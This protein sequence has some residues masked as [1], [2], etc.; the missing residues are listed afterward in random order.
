LTVRAENVSRIAAFIYEPIQGEAGIYPVPAETLRRAFDLCREHNVPLIADEVQTFAR[1]GELLASHALGIEPDYILLA[2]GLGGGIC[3][4]GMVLIRR[5]RY[6]VPFS[7]LHSSTFAGDELSSRVALKTLEMLTRENGALLGN[8]KQRGKRLLERLRALQARY[9]DAI[10]D[11]RGRGLMIGVEFRSL[12]ELPSW[13]F[14][15]V[16]RASGCPALDLCAYLVHETGVRTLPT[17]GQVN[18]IRIEPPLGINDDT[19]DRIVAAIGQL[20][21]VLSSGDSAAFLRHK[22]RATS[23]M[24][25]ASLAFHTP[26]P[27]IAIAADPDCAGRRAAFIC[28]PV[29]ATEL[30]TIDP[31][32][33]RLEKTE[34]ERL[35]RRYEGSIAPHILG[36]TVVRSITGARVELVFIGV[37]YTSARLAEMLV[38]RDVR[39]ARVKIQQA[40]DVA[41]RLGCTVCGLGQYSSIVTHNGLAVTH[42][43][44]A[45]TTGNALTVG[46]A[47][48]ALLQQAQRRGCDVPEARVAVLG[49]AGNIGAV[50]AVLASDRF[51][52][53]KLVGSG[54]WGSK[55]RLEHTA[56]RV[57]ERA[58]QV[59]FDRDADLHRGL[60][61]EPRIAE[62]FK[63]PALAEG[64]AAPGESLYRAALA[65]FGKA[66]PVTVH[67]DLTAIADCDIVFCAANTSEPIIRPETLCRSSAVICDVGVPYNVDPRVKNACPDV[68]LIRGGAVTLPYGEDVQVLGNHLPPGQIFACVAETALL[69][70][71]GRGSHFSYGDISCDQ[72]AEIQGVALRHGFGLTAPLA[73]KELWAEPVKR[74][75]LQG[76]VP[77]VRAV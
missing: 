52:R 18:T 66:I 59:W 45:L 32:L 49:A 37:P 50:L 75:A 44:V 43:R 28:H 38:H 48:A 64:K 54:R 39:S 5:E 47:F 22:L 56:H 25:A 23:P 30:R 6:Q 24:P 16:G 71:E 60:A 17:L 55:M 8:V 2:K 69:A 36:Q 13:G 27:D 42:E 4:I 26:A 12:T 57:F 68:E 21:K 41:D 10:V 40:I 67:D 11:V 72:V 34:L 73:L 65:R 9:P 74:N 76:G 29:D 53:I 3:K 14:R 31:S 61:A 33:A 1:T 20:A 7:H 77:S 62:L 35:L 46:T 63:D 19:V 58:W 51:A 15:M 70:L